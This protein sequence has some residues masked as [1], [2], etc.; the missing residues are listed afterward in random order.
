M[1]VLVV[2]HN[3]TLVMGVADQVVVLEAGKPDRR[4][5]CRRWCGRIKR[6]IDAYLGAEAA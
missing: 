4:R 3:M 1:T 5:A 6:V 2:E